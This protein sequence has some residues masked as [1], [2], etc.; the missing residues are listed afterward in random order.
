MPSRRLAERGDPKADQDVAAV[1]QW[2]ESYSAFVSEHTRQLRETFA[3][4]RDEQ[5]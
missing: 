3:G 4:A 1:I 2:V 5:R